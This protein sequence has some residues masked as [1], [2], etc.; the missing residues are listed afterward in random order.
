MTYNEFAWHTSM[1]RDWL[2]GASALPHA[3]LVLGTPGIGKSRLLRAFA[4][5]LLCESPASDGRAC[6]RCDACGW[7]LAGNHPD[8]RVL[9]R[10]PGEDGAAA[11]E[12][13]VDQFRAITEFCVVGSHR[14]G[15]RVVIVDPADAMN[16]ITA[17]AFLKTLEEPTAGLVFLLASARPDAIPA[18]VRSRCS[19]RVAEGPAMEDA[20]AWLQGQTGCTPADAGT[21]LAMAGG[22][23]LHALGFAE[24]AQSAAHRAMLAVVASL[25]ETALVTAADGLQG[26]DARQWLPLLQRWLMDLGRC[27][28]GAEPRYFPAHA[29]RLAQLADRC[30]SSALADAGRALAE[31][32]RQVEHPLN[33]RLFCE[34]TLARYLGAFERAPTGG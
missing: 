1:L 12:I 28:A 33:A 27:R 4:A 9:E 25:P 29:Q 14:G 23:P 6:G 16:A 7:V 10:E 19:V 8:L 21:W 3:V 5:A 24:P 2:A 11:R 32:Y 34:E 30:D 13:R 15:R 20:T 26:R 31:Q 18:T 17:N 22:A